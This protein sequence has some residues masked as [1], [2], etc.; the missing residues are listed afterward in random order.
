MQ[1]RMRPSR[2]ET[3]PQTP[4][5]DK[6]R[7]GRPVRMGR[8]QPIC[9]TPWRDATSLSAVIDQPECPIETLRLEKGL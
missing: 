8:T 7:S 2:L 9:N 5:D 1:W 6:T 4:Q 3:D